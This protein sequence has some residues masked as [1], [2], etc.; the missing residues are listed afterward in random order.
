MICVYFV[1]IDTCS[2]R[3]KTLD[4]GSCMIQVFR[5][6]GI[7]GFVEYVSVKCTIDIIEL[8]TW[9]AAGTMQHHNTH[10]YYVNRPTA[11]RTWLMSYSRIHAGGINMWYGEYHTIEVVL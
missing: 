8:V 9:I 5:A 3:G 11:R 6:R 4:P 7:C 1:G 10:S 2:L